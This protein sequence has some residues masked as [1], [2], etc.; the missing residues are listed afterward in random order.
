MKIIDIEGVGEVYA[1]KLEDAG[2]KTVEKLLELGAKPKGRDE[3]AEKTGISGALILRWVNHAD[4]IRIVGV[5]EQFAELLEAAGVDSVPEL[6][7][8]VAA[9]LHAKLVEVNE[10]KKLTRRIPS[11]KQLGDWIEQCKTLERAVYH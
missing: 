5:A 3:L 7:H 9:N 1:K 11:E 6:A 10:A 2:V 4:L 8:R